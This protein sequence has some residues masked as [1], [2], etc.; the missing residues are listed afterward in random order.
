MPAGVHL[1]P[2]RTFRPDSVELYEKAKHAVADVDST[3]NA[4]INAFLRWLVGETDELPE[5]PSPR[6]G[7]SRNR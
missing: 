6:D 7:A 5:R 3:L 2:A 4:H 1:K